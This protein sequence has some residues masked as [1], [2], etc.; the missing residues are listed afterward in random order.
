[1]PPVLIAF[2]SCRID[3]FYLATDNNK[4][5]DGDK[6]HGSAS[7]KQREV[8]YLENG[9]GA[10][11]D[12]HLLEDLVCTLFPDCVTPPHP[13]REHQTINTGSFCVP[14]V[15]LCEDVKAQLLRSWLST[16]VWT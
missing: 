15:R 14:S 4:K 7:V 5:R 16:Q 8:F 11:E 9:V 10:C 6:D 2:L 1:M 13:T 3:A 12:G